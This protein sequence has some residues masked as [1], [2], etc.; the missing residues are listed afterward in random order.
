MDTVAAADVLPRESVTFAVN[1]IA[2]LLFKNP[3]VR[4]DDVPEYPPPEIE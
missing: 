4:D 2:P 1:V 3:V